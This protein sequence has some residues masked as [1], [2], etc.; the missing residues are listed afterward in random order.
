MCIVIFL[1]V[2]DTEGLS[3]KQG[4]SGPPPPQPRPPPTGFRV[5]WPG[6][7]LAGSPARVSGGPAA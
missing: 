5:P 4:S 2:P 7:A 6:L 3:F 1:L